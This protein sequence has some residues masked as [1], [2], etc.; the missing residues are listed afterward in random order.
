MVLGKC[1][2]PIDPM[3]FQL[4][5]EFVVIRDG[6]Q[7]RMAFNYWLGFQLLFFLVWLGFQLMGI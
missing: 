7:L 3:G 2:S 5:V 1:T 6:C 4:M